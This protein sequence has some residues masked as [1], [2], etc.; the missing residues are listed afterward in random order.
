MMAVVAAALFLCIIVVVFRKPATAVAV[1]DKPR[2]TD[3]RL[4]AVRPTLPTHPELNHVGDPQTPQPSVT[5]LVTPQTEVPRLIDEPKTR[6]LVQEA[7]A[8]PE[9]KEPK[10]E[11]V[12]HRPEEPEKPAPILIKKDPEMRTWTYENGETFQGKFLQFRDNMVMIQ[13]TDDSVKKVHPNK[14]S[15]PNREWYTSLVRAKRVAEG[16]ERRARIARARR[17]HRA[18]K[19]DRVIPLRTRTGTRFNQGNYGFPTA[20]YFPTGYNYYPSGYY[21]YPPVYYGFRNPQYIR[22]HIFIAPSKEETEPQ[23]QQ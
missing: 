16:D 20:N 18:A 5:Q 2:P 7:L 19:P 21:R 11:P 8:P 14:L 6:T 10:S 15:K 13:S 4:F 1:F 22:H 12:L 17:M 9:I 3:Q 23:Q